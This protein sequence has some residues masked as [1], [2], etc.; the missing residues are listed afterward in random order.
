MNLKYKTKIE[1]NPLAKMPGVIACDL[2]MEIKIIKTIDTTEIDE[3]ILTYMPDAKLEDGYRY[4]R[5]AVFDGLKDSQFILDMGFL[6]GACG[7]F[8]GK[9]LGKDLTILFYLDTLTE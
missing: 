6:T 8:I 2:G 1:G 9:I 5:W 3:K 7:S 4:A